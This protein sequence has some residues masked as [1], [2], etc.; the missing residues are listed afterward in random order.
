MSIRHPEFCDLVD[1]LAGGEQP[2][3]EDLQLLEEYAQPV[4]GIPF[5]DQLGPRHP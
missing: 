3:G 5:E 4:E 2:S 1:G